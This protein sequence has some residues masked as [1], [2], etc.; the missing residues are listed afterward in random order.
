[1]PIVDGEA[2]QSLMLW[3]QDAHRCRAGRRVARATRADEF[4]ATAEDLCVSG[5][6]CRYLILVKHAV[7]SVGALRMLVFGDAHRGCGIYFCIFMTESFYLKTVN[8]RLL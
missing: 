5:Q 6:E 1:L 8:E 2:W 3:I 7:S 4:D